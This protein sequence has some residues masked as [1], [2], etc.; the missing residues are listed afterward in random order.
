MA[1]GEEERLQGGNVN[2]VVRVGSTVRRSAGAWSAAIHALLDHLES[3]GFNVSPRVLGFDDQDREV[4][5]F[6]EGQPASRPWPPVLRTDQGVRLLGRLVRQY[7]D[8]VRSF[9]PPSDAVWRIGQRPLLAGEIICHGDL[10]PWNTLWQDGQPVGLID[11]DSAY[12]GPAWDDVA[13]AAWC[14]VPLR[15]DEA[16]FSAG[17]AGVPDRGHR[18]RVFADAYGVPE[19]FNLIDEVLRV[20]R[21]DRERTRDLGAQGIEPWA[22]FLKRGLAE[23]D[24]SEEAWIRRHRTLLN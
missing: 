3:V 8:A 14:A 11:W 12:P 19:H 22:S 16:C 17:F 6:I 24:A 10:G 13:Y 18:L 4:L 5:T 21:E 7:H 15:D 20:Q 9:T 2:T 1:S 23:Q